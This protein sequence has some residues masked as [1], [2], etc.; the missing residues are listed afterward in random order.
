MSIAGAQSSTYRGL[1][2]GAYLEKKP[3][4]S[5]SNTAKRS[6]LNL[7]QSREQEQERE[8]TGEE[9]ADK[10]AVEEAKKLMENY[11]T[12]LVKE[13]LYGNSNE[14][15]WKEKKKNKKYQLFRADNG[16]FG[17][18]TLEEMV[19]PSDNPKATWNSSESKKLTK[20]QARYLKEKYHITYLS[21]EEQSGLIMEL[22]DMQILTWEEA[23]KFLLRQMPP[24]IAQNGYKIIS[25]EAAEK[26]AEM[27]RQLYNE[28]LLELLNQLMEED[29]RIIM[30][31]R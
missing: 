15:Y 21:N 5:G 7:L 17:D 12:V 29:D 6:F 1:A 26:E 9:A 25:L 30:K 18:K 11:R 23:Q 2:F 24:E 19:N 28:I 14:Q 10:A 27:E 3:E 13:I 31:D 22:I 8:V 4:E 16:A 20:D